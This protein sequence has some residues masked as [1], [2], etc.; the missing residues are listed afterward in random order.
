MQ[1][2]KIIIEGLCKTS[3]FSIETDELV[4]GPDAAKKL[5]LHFTTVPRSVKKGKV[6]SFPIHGVDHLHI[7]DFQAL[8]LKM[9]KGQGNH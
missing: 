6:F 9:N 5:K 4:T 3:K 1:N 8:K 7:N 2:V